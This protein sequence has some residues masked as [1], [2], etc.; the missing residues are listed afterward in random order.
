MRVKLVT[1]RIKLH[2]HTATIIRDLLLHL[3]HG[4]I[5]AFLQR[6]KKK[7]RYHE[8]NKYFNVVQIIVIDAT[9][10]HGRPAQNMA[11]LFLIRA[12]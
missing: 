6:E 9:W 8:S 1:L 4:L 5:E 2:L 7:C 10:Q 3:L 11:F 12:A